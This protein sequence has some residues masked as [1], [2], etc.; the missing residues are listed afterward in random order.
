MHTEE[1]AFLKNSH[2]YIHTYIHT[3]THTRTQ[4]L[5]CIL[6]RP[7]HKR[8]LLSE[9]HQHTHFL[10]VCLFGC[11]LQRLSIICQCVHITSLSFLSACL[12]LHLCRSLSLSVRPFYTA[13]VQP[14]AADTETDAALLWPGSGTYQSSA[15][16]KLGCSAVCGRL[17]QLCVFQMQRSCS[18]EGVPLSAFCSFDLP[19]LSWFCFLFAP[20]RE[21]KIT[22]VLEFT[23]PA[24][25]TLPS[26]LSLA[27]F[28]F[29]AVH[30]IYSPLSV[31]LPFSPSSAHWQ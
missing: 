13:T 29:K 18:C 3:Y 12:S 15:W 28:F 21:A 19:L 27:F 10:T 30:F 23:P 8:Q 16:T 5:T 20:F 25:T 22:S 17:L 9:L 26:S 2:T 14:T 11:L 4:S 1:I 7:L 24:Y 6:G 31:S